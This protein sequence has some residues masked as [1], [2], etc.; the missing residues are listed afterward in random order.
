[1]RQSIFEISRLELVREEK[2]FTGMLEEFCLVANRNFRIRYGCSSASPR[3]AQG[4]SVY[5][6]V[7]VVLSYLKERGKVVVANGV[8]NA[9][10]EE[11]I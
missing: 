2:K 8:P 7:I 6:P 5:T 4:G 11:K 9:R 3:N 10:V 1:M